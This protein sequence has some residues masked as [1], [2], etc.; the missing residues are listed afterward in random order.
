MSGQFF[1]TEPNEDTKKLTALTVTPYKASDCELKKSPTLM[2]SATLTMM[3]SEALLQVSFILSL[4]DRIKL[5][6]FMFFPN[7][8]FSFLLSEL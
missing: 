7:L 6:P 4:F 1:P 3:P 2:A 8:K 5:N